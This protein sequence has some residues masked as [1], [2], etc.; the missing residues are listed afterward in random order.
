VDVN[1]WL[2][3]GNIGTQPDLDF[4]GTTDDQ[5]LVI[6]TASTER[7]RIDPAGNVGIGIPSPSYPLH[8]AAGKALRIEG[9]SSRS[10]SA[11]Y[12][13][14]GGNG[15]FGI[16]AFGV[17]NGRFVV[18]NSGNVGI[19]NPSPAYPLHLAVGKALRIEGGSS[20]SD[21]AA[22]FSFGGNGAFSIDAPGV[23]SGR[24]VVQNSGNV[25]IG[26][27]TPSNTLHVSGDVTVSPA[28]GT[29]SRIVFGAGS[30]GFSVISSQVVT[31]TGL[32][33]VPMTNGSALSFS[34]FP[35]ET[36]LVSGAPPAPVEQLRIDPAGNVGVGTSAPVARLDVR[37]QGAFQGPLAI[38]NRAATAT[39]LGEPLSDD[40][41]A[42]TFGATDTPSAFYFGAYTSGPINQTSFGLYSY[43]TKKWIQM[44]EPSGDVSFVGNVDIN[45]GVG[46]P[47]NAYLQVGGVIKALGDVTVSGDVILAGADC[48]EEFQVVG[49]QLPDPGTVMVIDKAGALRE[50]RDAYDRK[51]AGVVSGAG[52]YKHGLI[53]DKQSS[54]EP[55]VA[56]A[57]M[58]KV[59]CKADAQYSAIQLGDLLTTS[60]TPGHAMKATDPLRTVG[61][62]MG[63][64]LQDLESGRGLIPILVTLQ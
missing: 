19:G 56:M 1:N 57:L 8:L 40:R 52:G 63:K 23:P 44:W 51:V 61:S 62:V 43:G 13:S 10:D 14:F 35:I 33:G 15:A 49:E 54:D 46:I 41:A 31:P 47:P 4:L 36:A 37:G 25:G 5:P 3:M 9:G 12:F 20:S 17:P 34:T 32:H 22:Y 24:F 30:Q 2:L 42:I 26:T 29:Q 64:A 16:D 7:I 60:P 55:R 48:A 27:A 38:N 11:A 18:Q 50:S 6:K 59:Y 21:S 53:L 39:G 45:I 28:A 58:G